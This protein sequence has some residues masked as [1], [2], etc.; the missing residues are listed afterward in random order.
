MLIRYSS[1]D[2]RLT[3]EEVSVKARGKSGLGM[4][5]RVTPACCPQS[6]GWVRSSRDREGSGDKSSPGPS[7]IPGSRRG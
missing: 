2:A 5:T 1:G 6:W 3:V 7:D 4:Q